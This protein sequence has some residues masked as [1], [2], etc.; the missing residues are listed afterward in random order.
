MFCFCKVYSAISRPCLFL[1]AES[2][3][4]LEDEEACS[5]FKHIVSAVY[6]NKYMFVVSF[7]SSFDNDSE[8]TSRSIIHLLSHSEDMRILCFF[9]K[10]VC[11]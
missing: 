7:A 8:D 3:P 6:I 5:F 9:P 4:A 11:L 2:A 10:C 1:I